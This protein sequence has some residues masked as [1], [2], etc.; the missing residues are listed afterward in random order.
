MMQNFG[1]NNV[2]FGKVILDTGSI[3]RCMRTDQKVALYEARDV[4]EK[5]IKELDKQGVDIKV[6][7]MPC[8][9]NAEYVIKGYQKNRGGENPMSQTSSM[10]PLEMMEAAIKTAKH[11]LKVYRKDD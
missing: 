5:E 2:S 9:G 8:S 7:G 10:T 3:D 6:Y 4:F 1:A 11:L